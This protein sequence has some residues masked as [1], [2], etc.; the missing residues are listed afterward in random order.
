M[1]SIALATAT[2]AYLA[3]RLH[4][5]ERREEGMTTTEM[6]VLTALLVG[7]AIVVA[8]IIFTAAKNN[9]NAIPTPQVPSTP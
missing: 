2:W 3:A 8:G 9:A 4:L 7:A 5:G 6:A 1:S